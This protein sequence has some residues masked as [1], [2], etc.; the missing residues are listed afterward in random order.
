[1]NLITKPTALAM[2]IIEEYIKPGDVVVDATAGNGHD[3]LVLANLT[4]TG[5]KV[6]AFDVQPLALEQTKTLLEKEGFFHNCTLV[7]DSHENMG[8]YIPEY[9][10]K[11]ISAVVFNLGYLPGGQKEMTTQTEATLAAVEQALHL[12]RIGGIVAVTMYPGHPE[13]AMERASLLHF[14]ENLSQR[15][16]HTA[17]LSFPNQKKSPPELLLITRKC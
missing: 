5:G 7:L 9:E 15:I 10:K 3:T 4:G 11:E 8:S 12:I 16:Y 13:G 2:K 6:Y 17:Y 1:M 14:S